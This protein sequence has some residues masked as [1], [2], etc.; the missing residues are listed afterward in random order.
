MLLRLLL[1]AVLLLLLL[2]LHLPV[3]CSPLRT[4]CSQQFSNLEVEELDV[5][6]EQ[7]Q[8]LLEFSGDAFELLLLLQNIRNR[9]TAANTQVQQQQQGE[10]RQCRPLICETEPEVAA[11][12][13]AERELSH[14]LHLSLLL[15][16]AVDTSAGRCLFMRFLLPPE[17]PNYDVGVRFA[18]AGRAIAFCAFH[19]P[20]RLLLLLPLLPLLFVRRSGSFLGCF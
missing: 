5:A 20:T 18:A 7:L 6:A 15:E 1:F 11:V 13:E 12:A 9:L 17:S 14:A 10:L 2:R 8:Q 3:L 19:W 4:F 16:A